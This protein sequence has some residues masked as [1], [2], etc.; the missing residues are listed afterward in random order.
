MLNHDSITGFLAHCMNSNAFCV[1]IWLSHKTARQM[2]YA[3]H[4]FHY[5][6][7]LLILMFVNN[8]NVQ[9]FI[10]L[11][12]PLKEKLWIMQMTGLGTLVMMPLL[13]NLSDKYG[14]KAILTLPMSLTIIPLGTSGSNLFLFFH[15]VVTFSY[16]MYF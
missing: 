13:G 6:F 4:P 8:I 15:S 7:P 11:A 3:N 12:V 14:R 2:H 1:L 5:L 9:C 16:I 10:S